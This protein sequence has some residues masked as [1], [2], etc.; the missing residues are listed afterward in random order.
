MARH[1]ESDITKFINEYKRK[2]ADTEQ[3]QREGRA[4]LWDKNLDPEQLEYY[5]SGR[6]NQRPYVY[7]T[8]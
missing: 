5:R 6:V 4:L 3:R 1:Y 7:Q 2:H 8:D